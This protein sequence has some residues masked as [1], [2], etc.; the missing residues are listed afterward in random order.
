MKFTPP[1]RF[2]SC[3]NMRVHIAAMLL[4]FTEKAAAKVC[5]G[6]PRKCEMCESGSIPCSECLADV[7]CVALN[8]GVKM[9]LVGL[10]TGASA[11]GHQC[12]E[13]APDPPFINE[14]C[15]IEQARLAATEWIGRGGELV[16]MAQDDLNQVP[17]GMAIAASGVD[18]SELFL[19]TKCIG[20]LTFE[21]TLECIYDALQML[22]A[23]FP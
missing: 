16:E 10:G 19:E 12:H 6:H 3:T 21:G 20:S 7:A 11:F 2:T 4:F 8:N 1:Q 5:D 23:S 22:Q 17:V 18:R 13:P 15:F 9:P 14:R